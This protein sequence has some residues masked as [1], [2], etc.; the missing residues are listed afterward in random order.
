MRWDGM[1]W[2][3]TDSLVYGVWCECVEHGVGSGE[4]M[5][6]GSGA[7]LYNFIVDVL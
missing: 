7:L 1:E 3:I 5:G 4:C 6:V 2:N